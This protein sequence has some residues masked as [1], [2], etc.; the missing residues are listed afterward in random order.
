MCICIFGYP[1]PNTGGYTNWD[2]DLYIK[3]HG[4]LLC[5]IILTSRQKYSHRISFILKYGI[6][7]QKIQKS[8]IKR[9]RWVNKEKEKTNKNYKFFNKLF[10]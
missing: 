2:S 4:I 3:E 8:I 7:R 6:K 1:M 10:L 5:N 9:K